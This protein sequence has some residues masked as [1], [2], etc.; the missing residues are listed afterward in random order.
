MLSDVIS[1]SEP[2]IA[3]P[4]GKA[5]MQITPLSRRNLTLQLSSGSAIRQTGRIQMV[6]QNSSVYLR[7]A[8]GIRL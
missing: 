2:R 7:F 4:G 3:P 6:T 1:Q 8:K 5:Y